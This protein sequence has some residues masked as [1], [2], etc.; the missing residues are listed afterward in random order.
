MYDGSINRFLTSIV[1]VIFLIS[2]AAK[3]WID[4]T[5]RSFDISSRENGYIV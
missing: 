3:E 5:L 2:A 4:T 1:V